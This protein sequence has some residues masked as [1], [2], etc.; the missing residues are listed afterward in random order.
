VEVL[1]RRP[2]Q[3]LLVLAGIVAL[4]SSGAAS[5]LTP[6]ASAT[7][8]EAQVRAGLLYNFAAFTE[9][10]DEDS[11]AS[12]SFVIGVLGADAVGDALREVQGR[13][14]RGRAIDI[15]RISWDVDVR[16]CHVLYVPASAAN[17]QGVLSD[18]KALP[19]LTVGEH[20]QFTKLGGVIR[21]CTEGSRLRFEVNVTRSK[22]ASLQ[23]SS[24]LLSL[25]RIVREPQLVC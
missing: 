4:L 18:S 23:V 16:Q 19:I 25:A 24:K 12:E 20:P 8:T 2:P 9:W 10:P 11:S 13:A 5:T 14:I 21:L 1:R 17:W 22:E 7:L 6:G 15:R 3:A